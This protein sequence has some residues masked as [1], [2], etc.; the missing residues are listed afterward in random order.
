MMSA[1]ERNCKEFG[2]RFFDAG[3]CSS[4]RENE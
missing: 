1:I 2:I 3:E 4:I